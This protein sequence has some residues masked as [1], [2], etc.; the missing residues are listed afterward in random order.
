MTRS[1]H[2]AL[3]Q[4]VITD[5]FLTFPGLFHFILM[6]PHDTGSTYPIHF[7]GEKT[8]AQRLSNLPVHAASKWKN[9]DF[10]WQADPRA[11]APNP[12]VD[13]EVGPLWH[14][15]VP[16]SASCWAHRLGE[17]HDLQ[18]LSLARGGAPLLCGMGL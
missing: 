14:F 18:S 13:T 11:Q 15:H 5:G 17:A 16:H 12:G 4:W 1:I 8:D 2:G 7:S 6:K 9:Q 3:T 10:D